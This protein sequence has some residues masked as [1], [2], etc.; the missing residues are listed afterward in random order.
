MLSESPC[1]LTRTQ[2]PAFLP[3]STKNIEN[4]SLSDDL[5]VEK[6]KE[7]PKS[8][9]M[10]LC[11]NQS[12]DFIDP[13]DPTD[14]AKLTFN[15][16]FCTIIWPDPPMETRQFLYNA[17]QL[18]KSLEKIMFMYKNRKKMAPV[19]DPL[20]IKQEEK[21]MKLEEMK[22]E[23]GL[24]GTK[25]RL[26]IPPAPREVD[27][28]TAER[29]LALRE[30]GYPF[31]FIDNFLWLHKGQASYVCDK[32]EKNLPITI[33]LKG[34]HRRKWTKE[35]DD[36]LIK[37]LDQPEPAR[38]HTIKGAIQQM[39]E[40]FPDFNCKAYAVQ[41]ALKR[42]GFSYKNIERPVNIAN[43]QEIQL[44][45]KAFVAKMIELFDSDARF[46]FVDETYFKLA[47]GPTKGWA[48]KG[49]KI[50]VRKSRDLT[51]Y[52][53][54]AAISHDGLIGFQVFKGGFDCRCYSIFMNKLVHKMKG[55]GHNLDKTY[56]IIDNAKIHHAA[57]SQTLFNNNYHVIFNGPYSP[58]LN[59]IE[60]VFMQ[61][62]R[63]VYHQTYFEENRLIAEIQQASKEFK[64]EMIHGS[65]WHSISYFPDS[66]HMKTILY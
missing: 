51:V 26:V 54:V 32:K 38:F 64:I 19:S 57:L 58:F 65:F 35:Y 56:F 22:R 59:P 55:K 61:W 9:P 13:R 1:S 63:R 40:Q 30:A 60:L 49:Q 62:K 33:G 48:K 10:I 66:F 6:V 31:Y 12:T 45:R 11:Q 44:L 29:A 7:D 41:K 20:I 50:Y 39:K 47:D 15:Y 37:L 14:E 21:Q 18:E 53:L 46:V 34:Q 25:R 5:I 42:I 36:F 3:P 43:N 24:V 8:L 27:Q 16:H 52:G 17:E 23:G 28:E 4:I 2:Q